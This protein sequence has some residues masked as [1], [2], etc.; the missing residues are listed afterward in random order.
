M[1]PCHSCCIV[2]LYCKSY[3]VYTVKHFIGYLNLLY[4][5]CFVFEVGKA[6]S[7]TQSVVMILIMTAEWAARK[8][9]EGSLI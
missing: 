8:C 1:V 9:F 7:A 4:C 2:K 5:C 6:K 3:R